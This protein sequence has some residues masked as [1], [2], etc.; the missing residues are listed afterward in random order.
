M[1]GAPAA[2]TEATDRMNVILLGRHSEQIR[3]AV[4]H[5]KTIAVLGLAYKPD[6]SVVEESQGLALAQSLLGNGNR[7]IVFDPLAMDNAKQ[8]LKDGVE[9]AQS[10]REG[11]S[12]ADAVV[13]TNPSREFQSLRVEDFPRRSSPVLVFDCWRLLQ[14]KLG[15]CGW[16]DYRPLGVQRHR[17]DKSR[18]FA[19]LWQ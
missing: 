10:A 14:G 9:Y 5:G 13:I 19:S 3:K 4:G 12:K 2:I 17:E 18:Q 16:I 6:T 15:Q 8:V 7:V 11:L 1:L